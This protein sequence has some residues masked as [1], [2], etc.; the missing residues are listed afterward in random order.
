MREE[1]LLPAYGQYP[2]SFPG[3]HCCG[4]EG[5]RIL[6]APPG[7]DP[8][9]AKKEENMSNAEYAAAMRKEAENRKGYM[10]ITVELWLQLAERI[11][12]SPDP[13]GLA[14]FRGIDYA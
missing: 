4:S 12:A 11:E 7:T 8:P 14:D 9:D 2:G 6:P 3:P 1:K 13:K 10:P 5:H